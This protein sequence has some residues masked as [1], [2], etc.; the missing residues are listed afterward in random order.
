[1]Y[2]VT[3]TFQVRAHCFENQAFVPSSKSTHV[4]S[5]DPF[6]VKRLDDGEHRRPEVAVVVRSLSSSGLGERLAREATSDD[7]D[8]GRVFPSTHSFNPCVCGVGKS[9]DITVE[10]RFGPVLAEDVLAEAVPL[11]EGVEDVFLSEDFID[12]ERETSDT[13]KESDVVKFFFTAS[14]IPCM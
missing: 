5:D 3:F 13:F 14:D 12:S 9:A 1:L 8:T 6:G 2:F 11:N 10:F 4:L 7:S